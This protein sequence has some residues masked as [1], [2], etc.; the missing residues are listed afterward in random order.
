MSILT[1]I[2]GGIF[3]VLITGTIIV[4]KHLY[5]IESELR[6]IQRNQRMPKDILVKY[7]GVVDDDEHKFEKISEKGKADDDH[8]GIGLTD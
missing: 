5:V 4:I 8:R 6:K 7:C 1:S 3:G 2:V